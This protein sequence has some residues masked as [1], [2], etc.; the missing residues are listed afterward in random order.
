MKVFEAQVQVAARLK[1]GP[2]ISFL[3]N[4]LVLK[5]KKNKLKNKW[6]VERDEKNKKLIQIKLEE[7][8]IEMIDLYDEYRNEKKISNSKIK[9]IYMNAASR[10]EDAEYRSVVDN[11]SKRV[12]LLQKKIREE[13]LIYKKIVRKFNPL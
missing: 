8:E 1:F 2:K 10:E 13:E 5:K 4:L 7:L 6:Y 11:L 12:V 3:K 9:N